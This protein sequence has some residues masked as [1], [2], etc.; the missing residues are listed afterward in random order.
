MLA[1]SEAQAPP[2]P[3]PP[4]DEAARVRLAARKD[5]PLAM[6]RQLADDPAVVVR[7][8]VALNPAYDPAMSTQLSGD[9][10]ERV[11]ALLAGKVAK[12][13]PSLSGKEQQEA[14][15]H[16]HE[17]LHALASDAAIRVRVALA[18]VLHSIPQAP[19]AVIMRLAQ[20]PVVSVSQP[21]LRFSPLLS[22]ADLLEILAAPPHELAVQAVA[23]RH[24]LSMALSD[25]I[26][27]KSDGAAIRTLLQNGSAMIREST[28]DS[29]IGRAGSHPDWHEPLVQRPWLADSASRALSLI[30]TGHLLDVLLQRA[31]LP[32]YLAEEIRVRAAAA[33]AP[34]V[35][36]ADLMLQAKRQHEAKP[37]REAT[38]VAAA[39]AGESR[40][41]A[42]ILALTSQV[43]LERI[44][45]AVALHNAKGLVSLV[46]RA[47]FSMHAAQLVQSSLGPFAPGETL[48][49]AQGGSFPLCVE[50]MEWQIERLAE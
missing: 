42:M 41:V 9:T 47:G 29:L 15:A 23:G 38:L 39:E 13:L 10:D 19:R 16:A 33:P 35:C 32:P 12:L 37:F 34:P 6:L 43:G 4:A 30:V 26:A 48:T 25:A 14:L 18:D 24:R 49:A 2:R 11:R 5:T 36:D 45:R 40:R 46:W 28:L 21:V 50:E 1:S 8:A 17:T 20:D 3:T 31:D 22:D 44:D 7:A 27:A